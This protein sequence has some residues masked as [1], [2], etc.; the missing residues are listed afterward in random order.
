M[1]RLL[2]LPAALVVVAPAVSAASPSMA[3]VELHVDPC[4][5]VDPD[6]ARRIVAIELHADVTDPPSH[7][8]ATT[9]V[10]VACVDR[11]VELRVTDPLTGKSLARRVAL[12]EQPNES[13]SRLLAL[14][15]AELVAASWSELETN[16]QPAVPPATLDTSVAEKEAARRSVVARVPPPIRPDVA[17]PPA[18][19][20]RLDDRRD[21]FRLSTV[22][23]TRWF[24]VG[25]DPLL[26]I[27]ARATVDLDAGPELTLDALAEAGSVASTLGTIAVES[28]TVGAALS[29]RRAF[30][31]LT[32]HAGGGV[33]V[34]LVHFS[35]DPSSSATAEGKTLSAPWG[36]P[37]L[38]CGG[39]VDLGRRFALSL[40][41][42][43]G[44]AALPARALAVG[45][46]DA[47]V[48]GTFLGATAGGV[49][50]F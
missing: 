38:V 15:I 7:D 1:R 16:P 28:W 37:M 23:G 20:A 35:G 17:R 47:R 6:D 31:R 10:E 48:E 30:G 26:G 29:A 22:L 3:H 41:A 19:A 13:R 12:A 24:M 34:G 14:A 46:P 44:Y 39:L 43:L 21:V 11:L 49:V 50:R 8:P 36:G 9:R 42:E 18:P 45:G 4:A 27:G 33:R 25:S 2:V 5:P 32:L 40:D